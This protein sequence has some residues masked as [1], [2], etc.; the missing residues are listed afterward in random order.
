MFTFLGKCYESITENFIPRPRR[1]P[2]IELDLNA[3]DSLIDVGKEKN[4]RAQKTVLD[5]QN[6]YN[7]IPNSEQHV[8]VSTYV[9]KIKIKDFYMTPR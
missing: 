6:L 8:S 9:T 5:D 1:K 3:A 7:P 2:R 4:S